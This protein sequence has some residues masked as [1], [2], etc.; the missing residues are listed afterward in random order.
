MKYNESEIRWQSI[1]VIKTCITFI[2]NDQIQLIID[3]RLVTNLIDVI[4]CDDDSTV[5]KNIFD[6]TNKIE[7]VSREQ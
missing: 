1:H 4:S 5:D 2:D 6:I 3:T 7:E